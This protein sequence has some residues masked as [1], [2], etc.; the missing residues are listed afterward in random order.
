MRLEANFTRTLIV[1]S[2]RDVETRLDEVKGYIG[3]FFQAEDGIRYLTVTGVQTCAL[4]ISIDGTQ[5]E[6]VIGAGKSGKVVAFRADNGK[7]L[8]TRN[9]GIHKFDS[10]PF[11]L[12]KTVCYE[13]GDRKSVV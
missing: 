1:L 9:V 6:T 12:K 2:E 8:W 10:G 11:P 3:F 13:P 4:P 7:R 5:T